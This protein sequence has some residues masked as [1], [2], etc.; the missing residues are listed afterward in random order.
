MS[1]I[2]YYKIITQKNDLVIESDRIF[3]RD[4]AD[5]FFNEFP[6]EIFD[7][8]EEVEF[9][10]SVN[11]WTRSAKGKG[12]IGFMSHNDDEVFDLIK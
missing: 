12:F 3:D 7:R 5:K 8:V 4:I 6:L 2:N 9:T 10:M 1:T 11:G